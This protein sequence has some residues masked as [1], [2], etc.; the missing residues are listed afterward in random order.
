MKKIAIATLN[1]YFNYGNRLQNYA[2]QETLKSL[3]FSIETIRFNRDKKHNRYKLYLREIKKWVTSPSKYFTEKKRHEIFKDFS[4]KYIVETERV[5]HMDDDLTQ[6]N[7]KFNY[8]VVGSDQVWNPRMNKVSSFFFLDFVDENKRI[9]YAPS[10]GVSELPNSVIS[11]YQK[12][13][14]EIPHL[15][16]RENDG[17]KIIKNLSGREADVLVDPTVLLNKDKW[18][19]VARAADNKPTE[20]YLLTYFLGGIPNEYKEQINNLAE[21]KG[22]KIIN[23]GDINES[24]TYQTGPS[25]FIDY[26]N[27]SSIFCTDSFHG[28]VFSILLEKPFIVYERAGAVSMYS[29]I[30]TL[31]KKFEL[32]ERKSENVTINE[33]VF[34]IDYSHAMP[35]LEKERELALSFLKNALKIEDAN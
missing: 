32:N 34:D 8:F 3:G 6:L 29:R 12:W 24:D 22:L 17:A 35:I 16:V 33:K 19:E 21:I 1:G 9:A 5:F 30:D 14:K 31:L 2:L 15:S 25:E 4:C 13:L 20:A 11:H 23:L 26:I 18:L 7:D 27:D 28:A 10:F